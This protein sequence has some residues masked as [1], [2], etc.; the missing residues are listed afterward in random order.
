MISDHP[1][2]GTRTELSFDLKS[3]RLFRKKTGE[4]SIR[5]LDE[6]RAEGSGFA[7][8]GHRFTQPGI[9]LGVQASPDL[10]EQIDDF[11]QG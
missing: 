7:G 10:H 2:S 3:E 5:L 6:A 4:S 1:C 8:P 9:R 11:I